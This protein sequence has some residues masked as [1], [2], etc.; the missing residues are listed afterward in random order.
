MKVLRAVLWAMSSATVAGATLLTWVLVGLMLK[1]HA[2]F[3]GWASFFGGLI[4][5][6]IVGTFGQTIIERIIGGPPDFDPIDYEGYLYLKD[7]SNDEMRNRLAW[8]ICYK[9]GGIGNQFSERIK[10]EE[11]RMS[12]MSRK[13]LVKASIKFNKEEEARKEAEEAHREVEETLENT[14][15]ESTYSHSHAR[16]NSHYN[17]HSD[18]YS[19]SHSNSNR[20]YGGI[21]QAG[22][23]G[24]ERVKRI[25][26]QLSFPN[27]VINDKYIDNINSVK[28]AQID[29]F[30]VS[31]K[32]IVMIETKNYAGE[33]DMTDEK[34]WIQT[35][36]SGERR[37][38]TNAYYQSVTHYNIMRNLMKKHGFDDIR[39]YAIV[40]FANEKT[41]YYGLEK[42]HGY[43]MK[44]D[45]MN[46]YL[47]GLPA[48]KAMKDRQ[49]RNEVIQW[50]R[51]FKDAGSYDQERNYSR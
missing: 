39:V 15:S 14:Y 40:V 38:C 18:S 27:T 33:I 23:E 50:I 3:G 30:V 8:D 37:A 47:T 26:Q 2:L 17:A 32:G 45:A 10:K 46:Y 16:P 20:H 11:E 25:L 5:A 28:D 13:E 36:P 4:T 48:C 29:H 51:S 31:E 41:I 21:I 6:L 7:L 19:R 35:I 43:V 42:Y 12:S 1:K 49:R 24:E 44:Y 9:E 22:Q 34:Q